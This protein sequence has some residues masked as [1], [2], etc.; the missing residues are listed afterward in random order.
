MVSLGHIGL[1][2]SGIVP[3]VS[4]NIGSG[5]GLSPNQCQAITWTNASLLS[6]GPSGTNI[7]ETLIQIQKLY[8]RKCI[9]K[10]CLQ[11][12]DHNVLASMSTVSSG[13]SLLHRQHCT[14]NR[15]GVSW[16]R[17]LKI[18]SSSWPHDQKK[19]ACVH[20]VYD[21]RINGTKHETHWVNDLK[22]CCNKRFIK[23][24]VAFK[25]SPANWLPS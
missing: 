2:Y 15:G 20:F 18:L 1:I 16:S 19:Y 25:L 3:Q 13:D 6:T 24:F 14:I 22:F 21:S 7:S 8:S 11:R 12:G 17:P 4:V 5:N 23:A 10:C 9:W